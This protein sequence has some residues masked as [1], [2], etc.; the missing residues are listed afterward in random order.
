M[1]PGKHKKML[2]TEIRT[3]RWSRAKG[4]HHLSFLLKK[5]CTRICIP[6]VRFRER[7][8]ASQ[9]LSLL[10]LSLTL[11]WYPANT[12][13]MRQ[14]QQKRLNERRQVPDPGFLR[15][16]GV[17]SHLYHVG[18]VQSFIL[19]WILQ[20]IKSQVFTSVYILREQFCS[21]NHNKQATERSLKQELSI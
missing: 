13:E 19:P 17:S 21:A 9:M 7:K 14:L 18:L 3:K 12:V 8:R 11:L 16:S 5:W 10:W 2:G 1:E 20:K 15:L 4:D 6:K